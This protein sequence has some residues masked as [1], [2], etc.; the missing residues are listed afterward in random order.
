MHSDLPDANPISLGNQFQ[1]GAVGRP[2]IHI[3]PTNLAVLSSGRVSRQRLAE[4]YHADSI[5]MH[6]LSHARALTCKIVV[7][8]SILLLIYLNII[9]AKYTERW[10]LYYS[11][12]GPI[13]KLEIQQILVSTSSSRITSDRLVKC[14]LI[15][16]KSNV[17]SNVNVKSKVKVKAKSWTWKRTWNCLVEMK[18]WHCRTSP[19]KP[20]DCYLPGNESLVFESERER[21]KP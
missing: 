20:N 14:I 19:G 15:V 1:T 11:P 4:L 13:M 17:E 9:L 18:T 8:V 5:P 21:W 3:L 7:D 2:S 16:E 12:Y 10:G 6:N